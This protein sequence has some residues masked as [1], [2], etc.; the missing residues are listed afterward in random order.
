MIEKSTHQ[1]L[2]HMDKYTL[3]GGTTTTNFHKVKQKWA[4]WAEILKLFLS[5]TGQPA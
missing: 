3:N 5:C 1:D 2:T 4:L